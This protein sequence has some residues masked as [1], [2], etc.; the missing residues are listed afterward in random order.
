MRVMI[1]GATGMVG[2]GV[3]LECLNNKAVNEVLIIGRKH[4]NRSHPKLK[5][6]LLNDFADIKNHTESLKNYDGCFFC[7]GVSSVGETEESFTKKT[8]DF[9]VPFAITLSEIN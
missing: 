3:L 6:L 1:T 8:Y 5:E 4:Y 2:E 9:V 7:A